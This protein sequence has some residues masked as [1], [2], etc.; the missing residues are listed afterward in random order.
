M[1]T[2][3]AKMMIGDS[4]YKEEPIDAVLGAYCV[5]PLHLRNGRIVK[6]IFTPVKGDRSE[7]RLVE[8]EE[9]AKRI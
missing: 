5:Y 2:K 9:M 8:I 7:W 3:T 1:E 6:L 4:V